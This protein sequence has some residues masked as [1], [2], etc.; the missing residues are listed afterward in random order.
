MS[1][2]NTANY[3]VISPIPELDVP[4]IFTEQN[5]P[6]EIAEH[7]L[8]YI[9]N[10]NDLRNL[11]KLKS[12]SESFQK[13][14]EDFLKR[15][16]YIQVENIGNNNKFDYKKFKSFLLPLT[17]VNS[18]AIYGKELDENILS[19]IYEYIQTKL[20]VLILRNTTGLNFNDFGFI[21][22]NF[23]MLRYL[24]ISGT[25]LINIELSLL[26]EKLFNIE[27][28]IAN[29]IGP[30]VTFESFQFISKR[31]KKIEI[32][33]SENFNA[34]T[35]V[36]F[37]AK[38][39]TPK[40]SYLGLKIGAF[41]EI[42]WDSDEFKKISSTIEIFKLEF[43]TNKEYNLID[44][45]QFV[46]NKLKALVLQ[47]TI[48]GDNKPTLTDKALYEILSGQGRLE[49]LSLKSN[50]NN[51]DVTNDIL[52]LLRYRCPSITELE[53]VQISG[54][55]H[56][57]QRVDSEQI[58]RFVLNTLALRGIK[59]LSLMNIIGI[60]DGILIKIIENHRNLKEL[61]INL[62]ESITSLTVDAMKRK[63]KSTDG[64]Y[65]LK[66]L[67]IMDSTSN[68]PHNFTLKNVIPIEVEE[69]TVLSMFKEN[70]YKID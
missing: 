53:L 40:L 33:L 21:T 16:Q 6:K 42:S 23:Y 34:C 11:L 25:R 3:R 18:I 46:D 61:R 17:E 66:C 14:V 2:R 12:V 22:V 67:G 59:L 1:L 32:D 50:K 10:P 37:L 60:G 49:A 4:S 36:S 15:K 62:N 43:F 56:A 24:D 20:Q 41:S 13:S 55:T 47:E 5:L 69:F 65:V 38:A 64:K 29:N 35:F 57:Y 52:D 44:L 58:R 30:Q 51:F 48:I 63:A 28:L 68:N 7:I 27:V 26:A 19:L 54:V 8:S 31:I 70:Q 9:F 45:N 39:E